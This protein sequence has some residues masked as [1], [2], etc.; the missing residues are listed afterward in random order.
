LSGPKPTL[1]CPCAGRYLAPA[2]TYAAPPDG[3]TRFALDA[4]AYARSY[5]KCSLCGHWFARHDIDIGAL[6]ESEY[7]DSTYGGVDGMRNRLQKILALPPERSDNAGRVARLIGFAAAR[8]GDSDARR[9]LLD[10]GAGIGVF[11]AAMKAAGWNV[12]AVEPDPRTAQHLRETVGVEAQAVP[13]EALGREFAARF[14]AVTFNKVLEHVEDPVAMLSAARAL[15]APG[16]F[17]YIEVPDAD[18]AAAEGPG[19]EEFF[20]EHHHVFTGASLALTARR[21]GYMPFEIQQIREPSTKFTLIA[22][23]ALK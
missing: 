8:F 14:D 18:A 19:R 23:L 20:I 16:G 9:S 6:Y 21:A 15:L 7:V 11:P 22:A 17:V 12:V 4:A 1:Q 2:F 10:V 5:D 3:E 13:I